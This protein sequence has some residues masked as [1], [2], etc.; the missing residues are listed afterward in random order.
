MHRGKNKSAG[1]EAGVE[2]AIEAQ[3][4]RSGCK[5]GAGQEENEE[6]KT[7]EQDEDDCITK[8]YVRRHFVRPIVQIPSTCKTDCKEHTHLTFHA[9]SLEFPIEM[10]RQVL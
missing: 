1:G 8:N 6:E 7:D 5:R 10:R 4:R 9:A 2:G 3:G